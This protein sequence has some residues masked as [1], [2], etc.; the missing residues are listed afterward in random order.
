M[1]KSLISISRLIQDNDVFVEFTKL[2]CAIKDMKTR[3]VLLEGRTCHG[4]YYLTKYESFF[5]EV[6]NGDLWHLRL[7]HHSSHVLTH[8]S[9]TK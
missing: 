9:K 5:S 7:G 3:E 8:L 4:L 2:D 1:T 6:S